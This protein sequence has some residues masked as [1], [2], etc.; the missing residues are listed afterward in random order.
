MPDTPTKLNDYPNYFNTTALFRPEK[1]S[2]KRGKVKNSKKSEA[3][4]DLVNMIRS[5]KWTISAKFNCTSS[6]A[7]TF[8]E[9]DDLD[10]FTL[11]TYDPKANAYVEKIVRLENFSA[12]LNVYS[13]ETEKTIGAWEVS[14]DI[15]E[16]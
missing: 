4:T 15:V 2:V 10:S 14:F 9:F 5:N 12:E 7:K 8:E 16:F 11:K 13:G 3:G 1:W 6:W